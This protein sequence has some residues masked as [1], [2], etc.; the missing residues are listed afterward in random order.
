MVTGVIDQVGGPWLSLRRGLAIVGGREPLTRVSLAGRARQRAR[1]L[2]GR[3]ER[4]MWLWWSSLS[5]WMFLFSPEEEAHSGLNRSR[6]GRGGCLFERC[7][8]PP[9]SAPC[10]P[11]LAFLLPSTLLSPRHDS[12]TLYKAELVFSS[13][14]VLGIPHPQSPDYRVHPVPLITS[15]IGLGVGADHCTQLLSTTEIYI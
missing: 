11:A 7:G 4:S 8:D 13:C 5:R 10:R 14:R 6:L 3:I 15:P 2:H 12:P 1:M 9:I